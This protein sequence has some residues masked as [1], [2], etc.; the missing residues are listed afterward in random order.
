MI[1][2]ILLILNNPHLYVHY[3]RTVE[4]LTHYFCSGY[5]KW[6]TLAF[7]GRLMSLLVLTHTGVSPRPHLEAAE[8]LT[9]YKK[10]V[11]FDQYTDGKRNHQSI[12]SRWIT[13]FSIHMNFFSS[14]AS[15]PPGVSHSPFARL[16]CTLFRLFHTIIRTAN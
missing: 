14:L 16:E 2:T 5:R 9:S 15:S 8:K 4:M 12:Y 11:D 1:L 6:N 7:R 3:C 10:V 13:S